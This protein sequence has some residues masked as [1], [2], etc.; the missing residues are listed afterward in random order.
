MKLELKDLDN[1]H[2]YLRLLER[3]N[4]DVMKMH[5]IW[6]LENESFT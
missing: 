5:G 3:L 1:I 6:T 4:L 2:V